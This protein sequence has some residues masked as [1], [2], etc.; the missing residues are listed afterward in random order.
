MRNLLTIIA[1]SVISFSAAQAQ[2]EMWI[3]EM[4]E[5]QEMFIREPADE[6]ATIVEMELPPQILYALDEGDYQHLTITRARILNK[7]DIRRLQIDNS[8]SSSVILYELLMEDE[9]SAVT[10]YYTEQ[11]ELL[12]AVQSV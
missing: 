6:P 9:S 7:R 11:G 1:L 2:D 5:N 4:Q 12:N 3:E 8:V 10:L